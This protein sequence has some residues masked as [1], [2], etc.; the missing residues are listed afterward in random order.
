MMTNYHF[1]KEVVKPND[2]FYAEHDNLSGK[3]VGHYFY[4]IFSQEEDTKKGLFRDVLGLMIT[5]QETQGYAAPVTING[6]IATV[7]CDKLFRFVADSNIIKNKY[8][9]LTR[10]EKKSV[11]KEYQRFV[12]ESLR[13]MKAWAKR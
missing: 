11:M 13:Q 4:C 8:I 3:K 12:K 10:K 1:N 6:K 9:K 7:C 2:I 5:T